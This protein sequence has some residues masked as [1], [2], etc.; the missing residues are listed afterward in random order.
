MEGKLS[1]QL[2]DMLSIMYLNQDADISI[3]MVEQ[4][5]YGFR[6]KKEYN[7]NRIKENMKSLANMGFIEQYELS[8]FKRVKFWRI[9]LPNKNYPELA[10][11]LKAW[12]KFKEL[13]KINTIKFGNQKGNPYKT[14]M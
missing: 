7:S 1:K 5:F 9:I 2:L 11:V 13:M 12:M 3:D 6:I 10:E 8:K 4:A 14:A